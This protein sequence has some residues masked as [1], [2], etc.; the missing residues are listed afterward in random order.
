MKI[1]DICSIRT[2]HSF[3]GKLINDPEGRIK[4]IQ[5]KNIN[6][7]GSINF[8][9]EKPLQ[10]NVSGLKPLKTGDIMV[11]NRGRF[12]A[13]VFAMSE[14][15]TWIVPSS[16]LVLTVK[17]EKVLPEYIALYLNS[18]N[19]QKLFQRHYEETTVPFI[20]TENLGSMDIPIPPIAKQ[21]EL[22]GLESTRN[23][24]SQ[25]LT[26]KLHLHKQ[27]LSHILTEA[28]QTKERE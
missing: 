9:G 10:A 8:N 5:P 27:F 21:H 26:R 6:N 7:D 25:L 12:A 17:N 11:V 15:N 22:V 16:I 13:A 3:R 20:S 2:G 4:L 1:N 24:Y 14:E 19:G 18:S 23:E 28:D